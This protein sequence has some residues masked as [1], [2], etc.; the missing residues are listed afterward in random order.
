MQ[1][2]NVNIR[3]D[4]D[5]T[6]YPNFKH[7]IFWDVSGYMDRLI[8]EAT[9]MEL[10]PNSMNREDGVY[11][12]RSWKPLIHSLKIRRNPPPKE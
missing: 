1:A 7:R 6:K 12:S 4:Q 8:M 10:H 5:N 11:L 2:K 3:M 9:E